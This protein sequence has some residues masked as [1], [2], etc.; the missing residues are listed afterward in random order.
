MFGQLHKPPKLAS[1]DQMNTHD[2]FYRGNVFNAASM[3]VNLNFGSA[4]SSVLP[5]SD[6]TYDQTILIFLRIMQ[7]Q[8]AKALF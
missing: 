6:R 2:N 1:G 7:I 8:R 5:L 3:V 4:E